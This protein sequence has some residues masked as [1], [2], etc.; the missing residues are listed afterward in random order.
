MQTGGD[1]VKEENRIKQCGSCE[2]TFKKF[3]EGRT[4]PYCHSGNWVYGYIDDPEKKKNSVVKKKPFGLRPKVRVITV[5]GKKE[6]RNHFVDR[7]CPFY[8][9][10]K[11]KKRC[12]VG[13]KTKVGYL[14][15]KSS[16]KAEAYNTA[17]P[18]LP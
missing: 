4:C 5:L 3:G 18:I 8:Y 16:A 1:S 13:K 14:Y 17:H 2:R 9:I 15:F 7:Y 6:G 11:F 12:L 10:P